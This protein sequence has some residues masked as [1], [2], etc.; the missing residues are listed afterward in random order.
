M[1]PNKAFS[2]ECQS[3]HPRKSD[4]SNIKMKNTVSFSSKIEVREFYS[5]IDWK[6][7]RRS[8]GRDTEE[9]ETKIFADFIL[10]VLE[11]KFWEYPIKVTHQDR[12]D[13]VIES[14]HKHIGVEITEQ[15]SKYYGQ[16]LAISENADDFGVIE[17]SDF[18]IKTDSKKLSGK[19]VAQLVSKGKLTGPPSMGYEE[20][21]NW[22]KRTIN[23]IKR[24]AQK[25]SFYPNNEKYDE[26]FLLIFDVRPETP[27]FEDITHTMLLPLY[28]LRISCPFSN[29]FFM[30]SHLGQID[31][32]NQTFEMLRERYLPNI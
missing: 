23:T 18:N 2:A 28:S 7:R 14:K 25:F 29:V 10:N 13:Y 8:E 12:P 32:V 15:W 27:I 22:V 4:V 31:L 17:L 16:A 11:K 26:N 19:E 21:E 20:E 3:V 9:V 30:D 24:K 1:A 6:M 5:R